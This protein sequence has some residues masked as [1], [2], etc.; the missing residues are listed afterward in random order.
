MKST[1]GSVI[2]IYVF[3]LSTYN[4]YLEYI[5]SKG[6]KILYGESRWRVYTSLLLANFL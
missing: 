4:I 6:Y 5:E 3:V 2:I 1:T